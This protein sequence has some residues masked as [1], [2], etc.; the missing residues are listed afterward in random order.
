MGN[1][2][3]VQLQR[4][5]LNAPTGRVHRAGMRARPR[6]LDADV[7]TVAV[8]RQPDAVSTRIHVAADSLG[9]RAVQT[10]GLVEH[11]RGSVVK[12]DCHPLP[13]GRVTHDEKVAP[14]MVEPR[15]ARDHHLVPVER[16]FARNLH[17]RP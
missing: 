2:F 16:Q 4:L 13:P 8:P 11:Q 7:N 3:Y 12:L 1:D 6:I 17:A 15:L 14:L 5:D 10:A 9:H